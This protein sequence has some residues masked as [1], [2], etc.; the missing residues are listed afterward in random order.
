[1][2]QWLQRALPALLSLSLILSA[3]AGPKIPFKPKPKQPKPPA[4]VDLG[5]FEGQ[6]DVGDVHPAGTTQFDKGPKTYTLTSAGDNMW[7]HKDSFHFVWKKMAG[8]VSLSADIH[9]P[10]PGGNAHRKA[11][12][13]IRQ[14]L[15][16]DSL[17]ADAAL[18]GSGLTA[19]QFRSGAGAAT[20][21]TE[22]NFS[23]IADAPARL[24][25]EKRGD[26]ITMYMSMKGE[27]MHPAG[28]SVRLHLDGTFYVGLGLCSHD[29]NVVEKAVFSNVDL[30]PLVEGAVAAKTSLYSTLETINID[31]EGRRATVIYSKQGH[32]EAP[33]WTRDGA[34][35]L[36][37]ENGQIMTVSADGKLPA[38]VHAVDIGLAT[39]C[40]GS[41]GLSPDGRLLAISCNMPDA[42]GSRV[43]VLPSSG[44]VPHM[45]TA[46]PSSYFHSWSP[47]GKT[48]AFT[49]PHTGGGD[50][51]NIPVTGG[52][53]QALTATVGISD[54]PDYSPDGQYIYFNSDRAGGSMQIWRMHPDGS[55]PEQ[56]TSDEMNN[57]T[58]HVSPDGK[59]MVFLSYDKSVTGHPANKDISLRLMSLADKKITKLVD[60]LGGSGTINVPSWDPESHR[61]A[62]VSYALVADEPAPAPAPSK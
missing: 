48:I 28:A 12:L 1:V 61:L 21:D 57:W 50:I 15:D 8:D 22:L 4:K 2:N 32:F 58:P 39:K 27:P 19:L 43:Y 16:A 46:N 36:F 60:L 24:R 55:Q 38:G 29:P 13:L 44:G 33:N 31:P 9:F 25:L 56:V 52:D 5:I 10:S 20:D 14:G 42:P 6:N 26:L 18:H 34:S 51:Y 53:E 11:A 49:R 37:D 41:H 45:V 17:Y 30:Q 35:L 59:W 40:N 47:D 3:H 62:F 7:M 54:D 23:T